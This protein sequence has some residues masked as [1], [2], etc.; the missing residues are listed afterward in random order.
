MNT[1]TNDKPQNP[2]PVVL[3]FPQRCEQCSQSLKTCRCD[4]WVGGCSDCGNPI[5]GGDQ[6]TAVQ[7]INGRMV[8]TCSECLDEQREWHVPAVAARMVA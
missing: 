6:H 5:Y 3:E 7:A 2:S 4:V 1:T 8:L